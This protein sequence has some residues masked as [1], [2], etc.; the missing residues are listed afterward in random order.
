VIADVCGVEAV[1]VMGEWVSGKETVVAQLVLSPGAI[2]GE[3]I[4]TVKCELTRRIAKYKIP[5]QF[6]LVDRLH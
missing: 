4:E 6:R 5:S 1:R 2:Q 3:V